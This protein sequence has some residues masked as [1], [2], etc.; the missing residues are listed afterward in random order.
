[1][2]QSLDQLPSHLD[3][4][5]PSVHIAPANLPFLKHTMPVVS[6]NAYMGARGIVQAFRTEADIVICGR[7]SDASPVVGAAWYWHSWNETDYDQLA[8]TLVA[9]HLIECS[10]YSTGG[11][12]AGFD[13]YDQDIFVKPGFPIAEVDKDGSCVIT[14]HEDTG[15]MVT[16]D[17][18]KCQLL[19]ELQGNV[20][21]HSDS[22]AHLDNV[23][24]EQ[25]GENRY[26]ADLLVKS[27]MM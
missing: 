10:T 8:G 24:V 16:V 18:I 14:K 21:V 27:F 4:L 13:K 22:K 3:S 12:F 20:Y 26:I 15:G 5:N 23:Q 25:V 9:G 19:Y 17:T 11:N 6:A 1:M 7:C 2:P